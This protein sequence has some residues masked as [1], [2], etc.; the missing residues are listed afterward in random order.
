LK[1]CGIDLA[2]KRPSAVGILENNIVC[3]KELMDNIEIY[4]ECK[5]ALVISIDAPLST[6]NG[7]REVDKEM[8]RKGYKVL[9]PSW[10]RELVNKAIALKELFVNKVVIETHPTSSLKNLNLNWREFSSK[11]DIIDAVICALTSYY[12]FIRKTMEI[13]SIDGS[14]YILPPETIKINKISDKCFKIISQYLQEVS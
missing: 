2:V 9:P 1:F 11:K 14:I 12:Y 7:F 3:V 4:E 13:S 6:S 8:I 10:M 5:D